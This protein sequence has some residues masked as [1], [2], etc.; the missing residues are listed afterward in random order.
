MRARQGPVSGH[1]S[2]RVCSSMCLLGWAWLRAR[3]LTARLSSFSRFPKVLAGE[4]FSP[5]SVPPPLS[6]VTCE[7]QRTLCVPWTPVV[8]PV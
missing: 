2:E 1:D 3:L 4:P 7:V 5:F 8:I 6:V